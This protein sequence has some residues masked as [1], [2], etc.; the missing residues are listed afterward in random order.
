MSGSQRVVARPMAR[1]RVVKDTQ[2]THA[3]P[4]TTRGSLRPAGRSRP[5][6]L[7]VRRC[8]DTMHRLCS[9]RR[10]Q[11]VEHGWFEP[12]FALE[13]AAQ[14]RMLEPAP[15]PSRNAMAA[16]SST[17]HTRGVQHEPQACW[18]GR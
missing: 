13:W 14:A 6:A 1:S 8:G 4:E 17:T 11:Y 18:F 5:P 10:Q 7:G 3:T 2:S 15:A 9:R 16:M 12:V